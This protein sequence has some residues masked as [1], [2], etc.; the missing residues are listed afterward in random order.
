[1]FVMYIYTMGD[2]PYA[3]QMAKLLD[4][5]GEYFGERIISRD[6]GTVKH[7]KSLDVVLGQEKAVLILDDTENVSFW[8]ALSTFHVILIMILFC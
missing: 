2:R 6:D 1:M 8:S 7:Q 3:R 4:P 5:K